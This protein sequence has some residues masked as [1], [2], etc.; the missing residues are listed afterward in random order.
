MKPL[1]IFDM[2]GTLYDLGDVMASVYETQVSF[3]QDRKGWSRSR[4]IQFMSEND[5]EPHVTKKSKSA[6][7][8]FIRMGFG[9][10]EWTEYR[11]AQFPI[12]KIDPEKTP[13]ANLLERFA[14]LGDMVLLTSN[15]IRVCEGILARIGLEN[16]PFRKI[17]CSDMPEVR[18]PFSK[19]HEMKR[20]MGGGDH[21]S[22]LSVG[23]RYQ[24]DIVPALK[25]GGC[26]CLVKGPGSLGGVCGDLECGRPGSCT[27]YEY[28]PKQG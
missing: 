4:A 26:G 12:S 6:T 5:V 28:F 18:E 8:L 17:V 16:N 19:F 13:P 21:A 24:T 9:R 25:L 2:D 7:E 15:T 10:E 27:E 14:Q 11:Q 3:L 20:L 23:D 1:I 22:V